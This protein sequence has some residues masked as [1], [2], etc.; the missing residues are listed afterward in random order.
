M[1][2]A[3]RPWVILPAPSRLGLAA[4]ARRS[5]PQALLDAGVARAL[6]ASVAAVVTP[7]LRRAGREATSGLLNGSALTAHTLQLAEAVARVGVRGRPLVLTGDCSALLGPMLALRRDG[8]YG[9]LHVDGHADFCAPEDEP[10]GEA[11][12]LDL[13]LVTGRGPAELVDIDGLRPYV[14]DEHTAQLGYRVEDDGT[15]V[16]LGLHIRNTTMCVRSLRD[17]R[18]GGVAAAV[19]TALKTVQADGLDGFW[20]HVD[21]DV[22]DD[23]VMPAVDWRSPGGMRVDEL[24][25]GRLSNVL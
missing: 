12:S 8:R 19:D 13:A 17:I 6:G 2:R 18:A 9:L 20:L 25:Y 16:Y 21:C 3:A 14:R 7:P 10:N 1:N 15:D 22:L 24:I 23:G 5:L 4:D 11:A